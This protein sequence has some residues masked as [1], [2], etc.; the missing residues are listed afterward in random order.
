MKYH[1]SCPISP[2]L[3]KQLLLIKPDK[4][5]S[6]LQQIG[7]YLRLYAK[8]WLTEKMFLAAADGILNLIYITLRNNQ[9][10]LLVLNLF[11]VVLITQSKMKK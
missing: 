9:N 7:S 5:K 8:W 3:Q 10:I 6:R 4:V 2:S 11:Q 1:E